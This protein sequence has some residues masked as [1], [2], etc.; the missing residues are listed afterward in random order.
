MLRLVRGA[1]VLIALMA[2]AGFAAWIADQPGRVEVV[3]FG[4]EIGA[5][6]PLLAL[7]LL[8]LALLAF[9]LTWALAWAAALP[10]RRRLKRQQKGYA[11][12]AAGMVAVAAGEADRA[13]SLA[14]KARRQLDDLRAATA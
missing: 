11:N 12:F 10:Q 1:L 6:A 9:M 3:W 13:L 5:P 2:L 8:L 7:G 4:Y 14:D